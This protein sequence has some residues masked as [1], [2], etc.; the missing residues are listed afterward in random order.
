MR[1]ALWEYV[2]YIDL[3]GHA[4]EARVAAALEALRRKAPFLKVLGSYPA[5]GA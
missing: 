4:S 5:A 1:S 3:E 2:F